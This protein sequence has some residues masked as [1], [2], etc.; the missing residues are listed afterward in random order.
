MP[1]PDPDTGAAP[2]PVT[3]TTSATSVPG[4][5][6]TTEFGSDDSGDSGDVDLPQSRS[7]LIALTATPISPDTPFQFVGEV[8]T[9]GVVATFALMPLSL[10][11]GSTDSPRELLPP[12]LVFENIAVDND[13]FFAFE[14]PEVQITGA[15]NP[16]TASDIFANLSIEAQFQGEKICGRAGGEVISPIKLDLTGSTFS[17]VALLDDGPLPPVADAQCR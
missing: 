9:D 17:G 14:A 16:I 13:G 1:Q 4:S 8:S 11:V 7:Y 6:V 3:S 15:A 5:T 10:D 12:P 2:N